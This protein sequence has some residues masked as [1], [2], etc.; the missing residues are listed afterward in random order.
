[1]SILLLTQYQLQTMKIALAKFILF[2]IFRWKIVGDFPKQ[3]SKYVIVGAPH[4]SNYDFI[5]GLLVKTVKEIKIHFLA[6]AS[7]FVFPFGYFFKSVGGVPIN[8]NK[9]MNMV[10]ATVN[11]FNNRSNFVI[12]ISP[13]GTRSKVNKWRTGFYHIATQANIPIVAFTFDFGKR[14]TEIFPPFYPTGNMD[15]DFKYLQSL[16]KDIEGK[17]PKNG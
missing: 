14:Q 9:S 1:M 3:L 11:E 10:E 4:T 2:S 6:K 5:I 15:H 17:H 7:L 13:E 12:A 8:R 16:F